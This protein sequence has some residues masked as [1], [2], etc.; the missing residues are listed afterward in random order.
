MA[1]TKGA[2]LRATT[3]R[4]H[5]LCVV[6]MTA[7]SLDPPPPDLPPPDLPSAGPSSA[8]PPKFRAVLSFILFFFSLSLGIF[9]CLFFSLWG[10]SRGILVVFWSSGPSNV[11]VFALG[12]RVKPRRLRPPEREREKKKHKMIPR[13][14]QKKRNGGGEGKKARNFG[15]SHPS[16]P[17]PSG[18]HFGPPKG[19][20]FFCVFFFFILLFYCFLEK[21]GHKIETPILAKVGLAKVGQLR[22][23][24]VGQT[25]F[26][27]TS[28]WPKSVWPKSVSAGSKVS[29]LSK[30]VRSVLPVHTRNCSEMC[31][32]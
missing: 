18:P 24:K 12:C 2:N 10:S 27:P 6:Q 31:G 26:R 23:A 3:E 4:R 5:L 20:C 7:L 32:T 29:L 21:E 11:R 9:S 28:V 8:G 25:F 19:V 16:G 30:M 13:E 17:H 22:L 1:P 15:L 14:T